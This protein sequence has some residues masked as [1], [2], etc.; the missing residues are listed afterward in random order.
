MTN[1]DIGW[2]QFELISKGAYVGN[3]DRMTEKA[4][5]GPVI[6]RVSNKDKTLLGSVDIKPQYVTRKAPCHGKLVIV[7]E[8]G[9]HMDGANLLPSPHLP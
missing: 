4:K 8:P 2:R 7:A 9:I 1:S 3:A 6:W 5:H